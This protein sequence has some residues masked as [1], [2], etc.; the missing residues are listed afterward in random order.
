MYF[1][2]FDLLCSIPISLNLN[3]SPLSIVTILLFNYIGIDLLIKRK[4]AK[5]HN[6]LFFN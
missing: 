4:Q 6:A 3:A 2:E 5:S 1:N